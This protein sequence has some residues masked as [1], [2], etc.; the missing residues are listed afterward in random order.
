VAGAIFVL[1]LAVLVLRFASD[2]DEHSDRSVHVRE[3]DSK[4]ASDAAEQESWDDDALSRGYNCLSLFGPMPW[5]VSA[6]APRRAGNKRI[7]QSPL[8]DTGS[9]GR[10]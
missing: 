3:L 5:V 9:T 7:S 1:S 10:E 2:K 6:N 8:T 4:H